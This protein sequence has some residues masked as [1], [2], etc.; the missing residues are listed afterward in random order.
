MACKKIK[1]FSDCQDPDARLPWSFTWTNWLDEESAVLVDDVANRV[2]EITS[3]DASDSNPLVTGA[4]ITDVPN[5]IIYVWLSGGT[6]GNKYLVTCRVTTDTG[7]IEDL[8]GYISCA[9]K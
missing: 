2:I 5:G 8:S 4:I 7:L 1:N 3:D 6:V 9:E